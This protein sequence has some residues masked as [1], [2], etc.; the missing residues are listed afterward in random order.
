VLWP[1][2]LRDGG[3]ENSL[4][5]IRLNGDFDHFFVRMNGKTIQLD[6]NPGTGKLEK[7]RYARPKL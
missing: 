4:N 5:S 6:D 2:I 7:G 1:E 3:D